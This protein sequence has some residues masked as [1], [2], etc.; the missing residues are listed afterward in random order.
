[1][2]FVMGDNRSSSQDSRKFG[3]IPQDSI[4]GRAFVRLW[5][6]DRFGSL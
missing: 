1:M 5:P 4:V 2:V 6:F 3:S